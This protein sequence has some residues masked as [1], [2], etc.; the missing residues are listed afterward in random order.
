[1]KR[2]STLMAI[3]ASRSGAGS[4]RSEWT[5]YSPEERRTLLTLSCDDA[6]SGK[7]PGPYTRLR[8]ETRLSARDVETICAAAQQ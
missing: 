7:M 6:K 8:P 1:M 5:A 2:L 3:V 4:E